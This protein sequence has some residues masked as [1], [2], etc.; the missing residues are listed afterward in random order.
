LGERCRFVSNHTRGGRMLR[1][2]TLVAA[3]IFSSPEPAVAQPTPGIAVGERIRVWTTEHPP[4][5]G[6]VSAVFPDSIEVR[7]DGGEPVVR[8][9]LPTVTA[10]EISR[11]RISRWRG[12]RRGAAWGAFL[13]GAVGA[14]SLGVQHEQVGEHGSGVPKAVALGAYSGALFGGLVGAVVGAVRSDDNWEPLYP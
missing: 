11:H 10:L 4:V 7:P 9:S 13:A 14:I 12:A 8:V 3:I 5:V 1:A 6:G 2:T